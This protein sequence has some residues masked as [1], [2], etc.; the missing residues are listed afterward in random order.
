MHPRFWNDSQ[1][2]ADFSEQWIPITVDV[3]AADQLV[4]TSGDDILLD[5]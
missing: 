4:R 1:L 5:Q 3:E 2:L